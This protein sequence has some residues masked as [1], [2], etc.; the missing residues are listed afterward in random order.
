MTTP[1]PRRSR[2]SRVRLRLSERLRPLAVA[3][4]VL[5]GSTCSGSASDGSADDDASRPAVTAALTPLTNE[6]TTAGTGN[7][8]STTASTSATA[9]PS[10]TAAV[11]ADPDPLPNLDGVTSIRTAFYY[12]WFPETWRTSTD[13]VMTNFDPVG[14]FYDSSDP[15]VIARHLDELEYA[16]VD[17][18]ISSWWGDDSPTG[19]RFEELLAAG[20]GHPIRWSI[21][22]EP[23]GYADPAPDEIV[24]DLGGLLA[25]HE[26]DDRLFRLG[27]RVVVFVYGDPSDGCST[28]SR[29]AEVTRRL[30]V[31]VV[32]KVFEA[33]KGCPDQPAAWHQ[34]APAAAADAQ[35]PWSFSVSPGFWLAGESV[36]LARDPAVFRYAV[37]SMVAAQPLFQMITTFNEWGEGTAVEPA[38]E[39]ASPSGYGV[40]L[41]ILHEFPPRP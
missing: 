33:Y 36:R 29:W 41:D 27:G 30:N 8:P 35:L 31:A 28:A 24:A 25:R 39:W 18:A 37:G 4:L 10:V 1:R 19:R 22:Y 32:L 9:V 2:S 15:A 20:A 13:Q 40:Y 23:E 17:V 14:G 38:T 7:E 16:H 6:P 26:S 5:I 12:P 34:Y 3:A 21:Y 11:P